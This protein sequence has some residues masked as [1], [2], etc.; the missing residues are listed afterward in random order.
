VHLQQPVADGSAKKRVFI[1]DFSF[2]EAHGSNRANGIFVAAVC[3][4]YFRG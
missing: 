1:E 2:R 3:N 4:N